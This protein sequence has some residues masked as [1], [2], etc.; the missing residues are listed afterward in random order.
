MYS[1]E[2]TEKH[3]VTELFDGLTPQTY[4]VR[5]YLKP[6]DRKKLS[7]IMQKLW[8]LYVTP[9]Q[10]DAFT[11]QAKRIEK[12]EKALSEMQGI[13]EKTLSD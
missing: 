9:T 2:L 4:I 5:L 10:Q 1:Q 8:P 11:Q 6:C 3:E 12:T 7:G 13:F